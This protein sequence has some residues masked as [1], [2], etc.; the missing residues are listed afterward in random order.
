MVCA[1]HLSFLVVVF[2]LIILCIDCPSGGSSCCVFV[3]LVGG[4][5]RMLLWGSLDCDCG[6]SV[7][8]CC[9]A[10]LIVLGACL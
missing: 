6:N 5:V 4:V 10:S 8:A 1:P 7:W 2:S 9:N 3:G